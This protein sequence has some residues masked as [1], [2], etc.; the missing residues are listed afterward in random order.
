MPTEVDRPKGSRSGQ[1][2]TTLGGPNPKRQKMMNTS[3]GNQSNSSR[4]QKSK[5]DKKRN[6]PL[7][8]KLLEN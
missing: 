5:N 6:D 1:R 2:K 4:I 8:Q 7:I 3:M